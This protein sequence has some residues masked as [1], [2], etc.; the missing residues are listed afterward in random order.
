MYNLVLKTNT[1]R[2]PL[3]VSNSHHYR[4]KSMA[5]QQINQFVHDPQPTTL[6]IRPPSLGWLVLV[7]VMFIVAGMA[8]IVGGFK[9]QRPRRPES[10]TPAET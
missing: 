8:M 4:Q 5:A 3:G 6:T 2:V 10:F 1:G 9:R 7:P